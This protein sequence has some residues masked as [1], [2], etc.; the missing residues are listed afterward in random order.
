MTMYFVYIVV[1]CFVLCCIISYL[2]HE[3][4]IAW[5]IYALRI[6]RCGHTICGL[7]EG[8]LYKIFLELKRGMY[9][10]SAI[11]SAEIPN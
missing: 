10:G 2:K 5:A 1:A 6:I 3:V 7:Y 11:A 9:R 4:R 8:F